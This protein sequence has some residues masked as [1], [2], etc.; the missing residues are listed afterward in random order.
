[1]IENAVYDLKAVNPNRTVTE[2]R[3]TPAQLL[4]EIAVH[5]QAVEAALAQ[6]AAV[7]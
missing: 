3:R 1:V 7:A 4:K 5:G 2:G 6:L